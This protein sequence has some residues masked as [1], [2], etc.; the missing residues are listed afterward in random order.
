MS[1]IESENGIDLFQWKRGAIQS[2]ASKIKALLEELVAK[3]KD[4]NVIVFPEYC[5]PHRL[6]HSEDG[7]SLK[8][9]SQ[10]HNVI[11]IAGSDQSRD[12]SNEQL[13]SKEVGTVLFPDGSEAYVEK[14]RISAGEKG[15]VKPGDPD[16]SVLKLHWTHN[17]NE[18]EAQIVLCLDYPEY[19]NTDRIDKSKKGIVIVPMCSNNTYEY[20][21]H[22]SSYVRRGMFV[23]FCNAV[24]RSKDA[25]DRIAGKTSI[26]GSRRSTH[27]GTPIICCDKQDEFILSA[28]LNLENPTETNPRQYDEEGVAVT[29]C[30]EKQFTIRYS[31]ETNRYSLEEIEGEF[32]ESSKCKA[33]INPRIFEYCLPQNLSIH[34]IKSH[35]YKDLRRS[36]AESISSDTYSLGVIGD[37]D[38]IVFKYLGGNEIDRFHSLMKSSHLVKG[39]IGALEVVGIMKY[40]GI[41][42]IP[43]IEKG[44][45]P[46]LKDKRTI[47]NLRKAQE[48]YD[49]LTPKAMIQLERT[50]F[51]IGKKL[52]SDPEDERKIRAYLCLSLNET[53][54]KAAPL[55]E[56]LVLQRNFKTDSNIVSILKTKNIANLPYHYVVEIFAEPA[57][58]FRHILG[59][60]TLA[61]DIKTSLASTT[62]IAVETISDRIV[63][64][65]L[66]EFIKHDK[67]GDRKVD[68]I[69][70][71][72]KREN[73]HLE[74]KSSMLWDYTA[75]RANKDREVDI[76]R[77]VAAFANSKGG[78]LLV[79]VNDQGGVLGIEKDFECMRINNDDQYQ[80]RFNAIMKKYLEKEMELDIEVDFHVLDEKKVC[81][82]QVETASRPV[83]CLKNE[84]QEFFVRRG[85][86][87]ISLDVKR[88]Q[89]YMTKRFK[90]P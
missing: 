83:F 51:V 90:N 21:T 5:V 30:K 67:N 43:T 9:F 35:N 16:K 80:R 36:L 50:R 40:E 71:L 85:N 87:T 8:R 6:L 13:Y 11:I 57:V 48:N 4:V 53:R 76:V 72:K 81:V 63:Q 64:G 25:R 20:E 19:Y 1:V 58:V 45:I 10:Q 60:H 12:A 65:T 61:E 23:A 56:S 38:V 69:G 62:Y 44:E 73:T 41:A 39:D 47:I 46:S 75:N 88:A 18:Y 15:V 26:F 14:H 84:Q 52:A 27:Q 33:I 68:V 2:I 89:G 82:I 17:G 42:D 31:S 74:F 86:E 77:T 7:F 79:G 29:V 34:F 32:E 3:R 37:F 66:M 54:D 70:L 24:D 78:I 22:V 59:I 49:S 28:E 55:F